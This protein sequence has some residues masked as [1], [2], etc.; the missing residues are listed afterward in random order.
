MINNVEPD[1]KQLSPHRSLGILGT[2]VLGDGSCFDHLSLFRGL[3]LVRLLL[4]L[5]FVGDSAA[6]DFE[7]RRRSVNSVPE[8]AIKFMFRYLR[9]PKISYM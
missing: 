9:N 3:V 5:R 8:L 2:P 7:F 6:L 4:V 1:C